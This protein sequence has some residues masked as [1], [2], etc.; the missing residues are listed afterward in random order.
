[1]H[2]LRDQLKN[3]LTRN[4]DDHDRARIST[5]FPDLQSSTELHFLHIRRYLDN[6]PEK[7]YDRSTYKIYLNWL[8]ER[9]RTA[10]TAL[11]DYFSQFGVEINQALQTIREINSEDWHDRPLRTG[12]EYEFIR[13]IDKHIHSTYLRLVEA[14]VTPM[15]RLVAFFSRLD[16]GK[17]T[18]GL[19]I[20]SVM[21]ELKNTPEEYF[22]RS[23]QHIIRNGIAHG[24]ITFLK[25]MIRYRD[26]KGNEET[27][28]TA[29]VMREFDDL[30]D[31]CNGMALAI[32]V[33]FSVTPGRGYKPPRELFVEELQEETQ[34]PWWLIEGCLESEM[35]GKS[36]LMVYARPDSRHYKKIL[37][38]TIQSGILAEYFA[39]GYDRYF[40]SLHS[41][42][43]W[44]GWAA[45]DGTVL[46]N[47]RTAGVDDVA[48]YEGAIETMFYNTKP[49]MPAFIG[50]LDT[51]VKSLGLHI[52]LVMHQIKKNLGIPRIVCRNVAIHRN[53]WRAVLNAKVVL[54]E[55]DDDTAV[56]IIRKHRRRII[57]LAL[58]HARK[59]NKMSGVAYLPL[60]YAQIS[61]YRKDYRR[62]RLSGFGLGDDLVCT[63]RLQRIRRIKSPDIMGSVVETVGNYRIAWNKRWLE[64]SGQ[65]V[66]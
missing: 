52:P 6:C 26:K 42:K 2:P 10:D 64:T 56:D 7:F 17:G 21:Q 66:N 11:K 31:T 16:R 33:F 47:L 5:A 29:S 50:K 18:E 38:S 62:R 65:Q 23:Y 34:T 14:V 15:T 1:M 20:W 24:G 32:R 57:R 8:Q 13:F 41:R 22:L 63:V 49:S 28:D 55:H 12:N 30:L 27:F 36:Q 25:N 19:D 40:F 51:F 53:S 46:H 9:D 39:P 59:E 60:G 37:W 61:V 4:R 58:K 54:D 43:A 44:P 45:F 3:P 35:A 48:Q